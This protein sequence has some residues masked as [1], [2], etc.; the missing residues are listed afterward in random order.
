[1]KIRKQHQLII[2]KMMMKRMSNEDRYHRSRT[3]LN[4]GREVNCEIVGYKDGEAFFDFDFVS[5]L[6]M[7][8]LAKN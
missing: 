6:G 7:N 2:L 3:I 8:F 1:M 5:L 4:D